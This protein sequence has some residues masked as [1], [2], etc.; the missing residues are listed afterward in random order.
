MMSG[1]L[2]VRCEGKFGTL[3]SDRRRSRRLWARHTF[4]VWDTRALVWF[5]LNEAMSGDELVV[6]KGQELHAHIRLSAEST[7]QSVEIISDGRTAWVSSFCEP[8][9]DISIPLGRAEQSSYFYLRALERNGR[10]QI[11]PELKARLNRYH[12]GRYT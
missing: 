4:A 2:P 11:T 10:D 12:P 9:I 7:L 5:T 8:D 3:S 6:R 1:S